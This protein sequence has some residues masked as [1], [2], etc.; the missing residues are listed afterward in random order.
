MC[1]ENTN[2]NREQIFVDNENIAVLIEQIKKAID[3]FLQNDLQL[4]DL[5]VHENSITHHIACYLKKYIQGWH[6]DCEYNRDLRETKSISG[7]GDIRPDIIIHHRNSSSNL[8]IIE[9]KKNL[10]KSDRDEQK[11]RKLTDPNLHFFYNLG[12]YL[13]IFESNPPIFKGKIFKTGEEYSTFEYP[14]SLEQF[15]ER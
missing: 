8:M 10:D 4:I 11:I 5:G 6:I 14:D 12:I 1:K 13:N 3:D 9:I 2:H 15:G 7:I